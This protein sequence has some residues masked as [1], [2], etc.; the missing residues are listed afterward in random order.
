MRIGFGERSTRPILED[1]YDTTLDDSVRW[2]TSLRPLH[3]NYY[4]NILLPSTYLF[5]LHASG[6]LSLSYQHLASCP[7]NTSTL[8]PLLGRFPG[9]TL[10]IPPRKV[11]AH[12]N[13]S[14][15]LLG[16]HSYPYKRNNLP[17]YAWH[18][19]SSIFLWHLWSP[20]PHVLSPFH[21]DPTPNSFFH[22]SSQ[23]MTYPSPV[24]FALA[25]STTEYVHTY[26]RF[27]QFSCPTFRLFSF[28][29]AS[30]RFLV[31]ICCRQWFVLPCFTDVHLL[32]R[33]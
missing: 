33:P 12:R 10:H 14:Y 30:F 15:S 3:L 28:S 17:R 21:F 5:Y 20:L 1:T 16:P 4:P 32:G 6:S 23:C 8:Y 19:L 24:D 11:Y 25:L 2:P 31:S 29:F 7:T 27:L 22:S 26:Y 18:V 9:H 13:A